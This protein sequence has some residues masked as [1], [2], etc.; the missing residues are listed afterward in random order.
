MLEPRLPQPTA[1]IIDS[2]SVKMT[3]AGGKRGLDAGKKI[4]RAQTPYHYRQD[5]QSSGSCCPL[6]LPRTYP[7]L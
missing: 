4:K 5:G 3:E 7:H 6:T 1:A 2:Q